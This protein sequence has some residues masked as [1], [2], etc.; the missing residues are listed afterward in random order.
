M[1]MDMWVDGEMG[2]WR[3]AWG[4]LGWLCRWILRRMLNGCVETYVDMLG[5]WMETWMDGCASGQ[6]NRKLWGYIYEWM[7]QCCKDFKQSYI[8]RQT[9]N[10]DDW[11]QS[12][13]DWILRS[14]DAVVVLIFN[15]CVSRIGR[16]EQ[17]HPELMCI[18][19]MSTPMANSSAGEILLAGYRSNDTICPIIFCLMMS[20]CLVLHS[21]P[22]TKKTFLSRW[23]SG[24]T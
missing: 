22:L 7:V 4:M 8:W 19:H 18:V 9:S 23:L 21:L 12:R 11:K 24:A 13:S 20:V 10:Y 16:R 2:Q 3:H 14:M 17:W 1:W 15:Q 5:G 6:I